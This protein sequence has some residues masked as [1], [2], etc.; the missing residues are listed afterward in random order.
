M[1]RVSGPGGRTRWNYPI[2]PAQA[3][4]GS[5]RLTAQAVDG[6]ATAGVWGRGA[7]P[8]PAPGK[9]PTSL[10]AEELRARGLGHHGQAGLVWLA[11]TAVQHAGAAAAHAGPGGVRP[12]SYPGEGR[13]RL[14]TDRLR[15]DGCIRAASVAFAVGGSLRNLR[16]GTDTNSV[17]KMRAAPPRLPQLSCRACC[18]DAESSPSR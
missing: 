3:N 4:G 1:N 15:Q 14:R 6:R 12:R 9:K 5:R 11:G 2:T 10:W 7:Q 18:V 17:R 13:H 16:P 8:A